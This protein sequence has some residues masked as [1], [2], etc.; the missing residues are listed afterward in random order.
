MVEVATWM[1]ETFEKIW[2]FCL[3]GGYLTLPFILFPILRKL[4]SIMKQFTD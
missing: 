4:V 2:N 3:S 1:V